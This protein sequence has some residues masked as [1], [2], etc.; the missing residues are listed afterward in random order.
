MLHQLQQNAANLSPQQQAMLQQLKQQY[1]LMQQH[2]RIIQQ[3][4]ALQQQQMQAGQRTPQQQ[5]TGAMDGQRMPTSGTAA[6]TNF[7]VQDGSFSPATGQQ[8]A[9]MPFKTAGYPQGGQFGPAYTQISSTTANQS[10]LGEFSFVIHTFSAKYLK[11]LNFI[12]S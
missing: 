1:H 3:Q 6:Q 10:E 11:M 5:L 7:A 12:C 9:G 8:A 2:H 4:K